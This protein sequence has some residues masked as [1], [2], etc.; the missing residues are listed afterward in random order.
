MVLG[1]AFIRISSALLTGL[2]IIAGSC[3]TNT[4]PDCSGGSPAQGRTIIDWACD[5][6]PVQVHVSGACQINTQDSTGVLLDG[7]GAGTCHVDIVFSS[8]FHYSDSLLFTTGT[9]SASCPPLI[10]SQTEFVVIRTPSCTG[11]T[12]CCLTNFGTGDTLT[13]YVDAGAIPDVVGDSPPG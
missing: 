3:T 5:L 1:M 11:D 10:S 13:Q 7:T 8:G 6:T 4:A 12:S 9:A 2:G